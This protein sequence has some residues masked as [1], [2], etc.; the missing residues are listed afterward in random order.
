MGGYLQKPI[1]AKEED[2]GSY[3]D[4]L[5]WGSVSMQGWRRNQVWKILIIRLDFC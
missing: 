5:S 3:N 4:V 1:T 2:G